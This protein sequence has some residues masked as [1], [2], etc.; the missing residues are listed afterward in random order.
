M[1]E[2]YFDH[3]EDSFFFFQKPLFQV[4]ERVDHLA[5]MRTEKLNRL[6]LVEKELNELRGPMEEAVGFLKTENKIVNNKNF[7]YQRNMLVYNY[8]EI[9]Y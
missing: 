9:V 2:P 8:I 1:H 7:L 3:N 4:Q 5:E 6:Q